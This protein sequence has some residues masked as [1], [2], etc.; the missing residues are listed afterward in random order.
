[1]R[2]RSDRDQDASI[3]HL[4]IIVLDIIAVAVRRGLG[5]EFLLPSNACSWLASNEPAMA[6]FSAVEKRNDDSFFGSSTL[7]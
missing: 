6:V 3:R 2:R 4:Q 5:G 1:V 7:A